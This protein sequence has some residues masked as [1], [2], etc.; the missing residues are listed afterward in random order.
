MLVDLFRVTRQALRASVPGYSIKNIEE[1]YEFE[2]HAEV[3]GGSESLHDFEL[4][5]ESGDDSLLKGIEDYN[6]EDC[7]S[8][9]ELHRWL[10]EQRPDG[11]TLA[12]A[13]RPA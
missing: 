10:L 1:L 6:R 3:A 2:R 13:A 8:L 11:S 4:W 5:Q 12:P 7:L 9:Y